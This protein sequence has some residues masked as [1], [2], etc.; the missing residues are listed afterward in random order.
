MRGDRLDLQRCDAVRLELGGGALNVPT[1]GVWDFAKLLPE[2]APPLDGSLALD[3]F[4]GRAVTLDLSAGQLVLEDDASLGARVARASKVPVR[5]DR[6]AQGLALTPLVA[7]ETEKGRLWMELDSGSDGAV[8]V[9]RHAAEL[10]HLD[11]SAVRG[12]RL[13]MRLAGGILVEDTAL[14]QDLILDGNI[15]APVLERWI[16]TVDL[17]RGRL[18]VA[19]R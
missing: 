11:P 19:V 15:G 18:W 5:F 14:V 8:I 12:Q 4:A 9:G 10:L 16:V 3:A 2:D 13:A 7:V 1:A 6:S 17:A